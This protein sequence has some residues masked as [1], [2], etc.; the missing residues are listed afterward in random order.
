MFTRLTSVEEFKA[1]FT[2][3]FFNK[4][5]KVTKASNG[6]VINAIAFGNAKLG[7]K[8]TKDIAALEARIFPDSAYGSYLDDIALLWGIG[9]RF[10]ATQ[11][12]TYVRVSATPGTVYTAGTNIFKALDG[13]QFSIDTT[14]TVGQFGFGYVKVRSVTTGAATNVDAFTI[15]TVAPQPAGHI[16]CINEYAAGFGTDVEIDDIFRTRI[17]EGPD[18]L[19]MSTLSSIEQSFMKINNNVLRI[20]YNGSNSNA[21][22]TI[23][24]LSVNGIDFTDQEFSDILTRASKFFSITDLSTT[25][26][27]SS[28]NLTLQNVTWYPIDI[29]FRCQIDPSY[30]TDDVRKQIQILLNKYLDYRYWQTGT[31]IQW[32]NLFEIVQRVPGIQTLSD[33]YFFPNADLVIP[34]NQLPRIR[35]FQM[36]DMNGNV[37]VDM[38]GELNPIYYP[39]IVDFSFQSTVLKQV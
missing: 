23:S 38:A 22:A 35:G 36:L 1:I 27:L 17:E 16:Y 18:I 19:S 25:G 12:S 29:S 33:Q 2:E 34:T 5:N 37:I 3:I 30:N 21:G 14:Y 26:D 13:T 7:Q 28:V 11:S 8:L 15:T 39:N 32:V 6:S 4:T 24:V 9:P 20:F 10:G 31:N